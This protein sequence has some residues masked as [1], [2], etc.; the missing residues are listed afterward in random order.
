MPH[1]RNTRVRDKFTTSGEG[2]S[3]NKIKINKLIEYVDKTDCLTFHVAPSVR[4]RGQVCL[5]TLRGDSNREHG[6]SY[7]FL[8]P[9][10]Q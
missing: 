2:L 4:V 6:I 8:P 10:D 3:A 5:S 7:S 1:P 9:R